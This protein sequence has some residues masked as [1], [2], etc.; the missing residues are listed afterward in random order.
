VVTVI[1]AA[2]YMIRHTRMAR[3]PVVRLGFARKLIGVGLPITLLMVGELVLNT[4]DKWVV[5]GVLGPEAMGLY[6]IVVFPLPILMLLPMS[7]RQVVN[8]EVFDKFG[9]T[10]DVAS[11]R[12]VYEQSTLTVATVSPVV[13]G[14]VFLGL[15]WLVNWLLPDFRESIFALKAHSILVFSL[16]IIQTASGIVIV[17]G[18]ERTTCAAQLGVAALCS[19]V[20]VWAISTYAVTINTVVFIH[21]AGW[22]AFAM[23][24]AFY[25]ERTFGRGMATAAGRVGLWFLPMAYTAVELP[26]LA[27]AIDRLG[28][29]RHTFGH[30]VVG[31]L[32]HLVACAPLLIYLEKKTGALSDGLRSTRRRLGLR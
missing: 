8:V 5:A 27:W 24:L 6:Y 18:R 3:R 28:F 10:Q 26:L 22:L 16:L 15:P 30:G 32:V 7:L 31:G 25:V 12:R 19:A 17:S 1:G 2:W 29:P 4:A 11:T 20:S 23:G 13:M 21:G 9:H 14:A